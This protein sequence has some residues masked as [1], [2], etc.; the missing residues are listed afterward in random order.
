MF[1]VYHDCYDTIHIIIL[2]ILRI[3]CACGMRPQ[4][5]YVGKIDRQR[6]QQ[7]V[8]AGASLYCAA[9]TARPKP[10]VAIVD[11]ARVYFC[12]VDLQTARS[13]TLVII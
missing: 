10:P 1:S 3:F 12:F 6:S 5:R 13:S 9:T 4:Y 8:R 7:Q 2:S 11:A